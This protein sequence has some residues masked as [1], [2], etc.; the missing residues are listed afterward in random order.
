MKKQL[1]KQ[2]FEHFQYYLDNVYR[3]PR[4]AADITK[5]WT[6]FLTDSLPG[7]QVGLNAKKFKNENLT[8]VEAKSGMLFKQS[9]SQTDSVRGKHTLIN[10]CTQNIKNGTITLKLD[11]FTPTANSP[12]QHQE[13]PYS[14]TLS[15]TG[16]NDNPVIYRG[17]SPISAVPYAVVHKRNDPNATKVKKAKNSKLAA[18]VIAIALVVAIVVA[19]AVVAI[20]NIFT[21]NPGT[22]DPGNNPGTT[23]ESTYK[24]GDTKIPTNDPNHNITV[25]EDG[26]IE[27]Q[28]G[29]EV[30][31][32]TT[33]NGEERYDAAAKD[34]QESVENGDKAFTGSTGAG[35]TGSQQSGSSIPSTIISG[36]A[37]GAE[38]G[39]D[40]GNQEQGFDAAEK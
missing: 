1:V 15:T 27:I 11:H 23:Q 32:I 25:K 28:K 2:Q 39:T 38:A 14:L 12:K 10:T 20:K 5:L 4:T 34:G 8:A 6:D 16:K 31:E 29:D 19:G 35:Q 30:I 33:E 24:P 3:G 26:T 21:K 37:S 36:E 18:K 13:S 40:K 22:E 9:K 7:C 17:S